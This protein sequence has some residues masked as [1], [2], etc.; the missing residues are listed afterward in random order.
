ME[1]DGIRERGEG[2]QEFC[3]KNSPPPFF[4]Q[5]TRSK[6]HQSWFFGTF[7]ASVT[8]RWVP[9]LTRTGSGTAGSSSEATRPGSRKSKDFG[10][11]CD[12]EES[13]QRQNRKNWGADLIN[14]NRVVILREKNLQVI[15]YATTRGKISKRCTVVDMCL[16][17]TL[18]WEI[19]GS[20]LGSCQQTSSWMKINFRFKKLQ[21]HSLCNLWLYCVLQIGPRLVGLVRDRWMVPN[22]VIVTDPI[23]IIS[24]AH[25]VTHTRGLRVSGRSCSLL[26]IHF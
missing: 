22:E 4:F 26:R 14:A 19:K 11:N 1:I 20:Y 12:W 24:D 16:P 10:K 6:G 9:E 21:L 15:V 3:L 13:L 23:K 18:A 5:K 7:E 2:F 25:P 17:E 8:L